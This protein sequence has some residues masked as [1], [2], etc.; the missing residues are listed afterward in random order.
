M[1]RLPQPPAMY[2]LPSGRWPA[3]PFR[4]DAPALTAATARYTAAVRAELDQRGWPITRLADQIGASPAWMSRMLRG[5]TWPDLDAIVRIEQLLHIR[6][7]PP[8]PT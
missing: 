6:F 7:I 1:T 8:A 4:A 2:L 5:L 3:G